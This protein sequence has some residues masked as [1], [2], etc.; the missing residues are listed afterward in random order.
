MSA[1]LYSL[2]AHLRPRLL[3]IVV[4]VFLLALAGILLVLRYAQIDLA[5]DVE[6]WQD[7]L[8]L[9]ADSRAAAV[10]EWV[11]DHFSELKKL[12]DN[13]SLQLYFTELTELSKDPEKSAADAVEPAQKTYL[14]NLLIFT[15]DRMGFAPK[16]VP[17]STQLPA[18]V[19]YQAG[20]GIAVLDTAGHIVVSTPYLATLD[21]SVTERLR[22][23]P[24]ASTTLID[25]YRNERGTVQM[26]FVVP[27]F[28]IQAD[29]SSPPIGRVVGIK[30]VDEPFYNLL[31]HPGITEKTLTAEL[32]QREGDDVAF[33]SPL[34]DGSAPL[35]KH[36][37]ADPNILAEALAVQRPGAFIEG[38]D[39]RNH[40]ALMTGRTI[41]RT[42][43]VLAVKIDRAE[44][45]AA[46]QMRRQGMLLVLCLALSVVV[47]VI[48]AVWYVASSHRATTTSRYFQELAER[49]QAKETLLKL[50]TDNLPEIVFILDAEH[51]YRFANAN[52]IYSTAMHAE[53]ING[54]FIGD[55]LGTARAQPTVE[56]CND[57]LT[58]RAPQMR[59]RH[60]PRSGGEDEAVIKAVYVPIQHIPIAGLPHP[61]PGVLVV[62]QDI[63]EV[64]REREQRINAH[65]DLIDTLI[66]IVDRRDPH[67]ANHSALV[68]RLAH[69]V[70]VAMGLNQQLAETARIAGSLMNIGKVVVPEQVLTKIDRLSDQ[71]RRTIRDSMT[72]S[73]ELLKDVAFEGPVVQTLAQSQEH[74]DGTGKEGLKGEDILVTARIIAAVNAFVGMISPRSYRA[75]MT[76][77]AATA[78]LLERIDTEFDRKVVFALVDY[79]ENHGGRAM[80]AA[81]GAEKHLP[82]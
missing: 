72:A 1:N 46:T 32:L 18:D 82:A 75:A 53:D 56:A 65:R 2:P 50:V 78:L 69:A 79:I 37:K 19:P 38:K 76:V 73:A 35:E 6:G 68:A 9:I 43:W 30:A 39:Y 24:A 74:W 7:K 3:S 20:A 61:T 45:L 70:A 21:D 11:N 80:L 81:R 67:A 66:T 14:R 47:A 54:K 36:L 55:V 52:A 10:E 23:L 42:P 29:A 77:D 12:A 28:P 59:I 27:V 31:R 71:E 49:V 17:L 63:T 5:R 41:D 62:E 26:G 15:A 58:Y 57:A 64:M 33:L 16:N 4:I 13:P 60:L 8:N 48:V 25:I 22:T 44:A 34:A 40:S 51:C